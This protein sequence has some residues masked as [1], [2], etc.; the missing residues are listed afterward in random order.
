MSV[1]G[2]N[3]DYLLGVMIW[4]ENEG[5]FWNSG[6]I[7][8]LAMGGDY[9]N[10]YVYKSLPRRILKIAHF[11]IGMLYFNAEN[12]ELL[13]YFQANFYGIYE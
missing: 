8:Y 3:S 13:P 7:L 2:N 10:I 11:T 1:I 9:M 4:R 5:D 12:K 6:N